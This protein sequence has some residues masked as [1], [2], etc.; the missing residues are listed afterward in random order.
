[1]ALN[2]SRYDCRAS[3]LWSAIYWCASIKLVVPDPTALR[4]SFPTS[5]VCVFVRLSVYQIQQQ[6]QQQQQISNNTIIQK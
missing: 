4:I 1:M 5:L 3:S 2:I 6:Q